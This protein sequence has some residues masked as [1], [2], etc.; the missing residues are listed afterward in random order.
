MS[1]HLILGGARSGKS[2]FAESL[3]VESHSVYTRHY[4]ATATAFDDEMAARIAHHKI[5]R[6]SGWVEHECPNALEDQIER[7]TSQDIVLIDCLTLWVNNVIYNQGQPIEPHQI[8]EKV[9]RL[10]KTLAASEA[11]L[12]VVSNEVGLGVIPMGEVTRLFVDHAGW[13]NQA[14]AK[15]ADKVTFVAAGLPMVLKEKSRED[16]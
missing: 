12:V 15:V 2:S 1:V 3:V 10:V 4:V 8:T 5:S 13:M 11:N 9:E 6:G 16:S 7:F 14:I